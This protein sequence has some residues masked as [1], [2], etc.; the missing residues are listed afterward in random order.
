MHLISTGTV[1]V[2]ILILWAEFVNG[3]TDAPNSIATVVTTKVI[4]PKLAI[5]LAAVLNIL[6]AFS[7]TA[8]AMTIGKDIIR[9]EIINIPTVGAAMI[10]IIIFSTIAWKYGLPTSE[11]HALIAGLTG[12]GYA[13]GGLNA[14]LWTGWEKVLIGLLL[15]TFLGF[16]FS[17][18]IFLVIVKLFNNQGI[19]KTRKT[20]SR[21]QIISAS[22]MAF[23]HGN[24]DGQKFIGAF[25]LTLFLS[26]ISN[27]LFVPPWVIFLC[28]VVMGVGTLFGGWRIIKTLG[29]KLTRL[30]TPHGF[31]V[32]TAAASTIILASQFGI[33]I[34]TTHTI[35]TSIMGA[36]AVSRMKA[37]RWDV[38]RNIL[39]AWILTFP[40]CALISWLVTKIVLFLN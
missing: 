37:V 16:I 14:L 1:F 29:L 25:A 31:A 15:S 19:S 24:N 3:W 6:G 17:F 33:P 35:S 38:A 11:S 21:L 30:E 28:A 26:G 27:E 40:V 5:L 9:P 23:S 39:A 7:G 4:P 20:F 8:V 10:G 22:F 32:E 12:A 34:S 36:G 2:L 18:I 13:S